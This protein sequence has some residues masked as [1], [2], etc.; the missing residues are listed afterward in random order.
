M[1]ERK[2]LHIYRHWDTL[3][4]RNSHVVIK[5]VSSLKGSKKFINGNYAEIVMSY[6]NISLW[7][8]ENKKLH[9]YNF[10]KLYYY[11]AIIDDK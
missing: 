10:I 1:D 3:V 7:Y 9:K 8:I 5:K 11:D 6:A 2:C 4:H